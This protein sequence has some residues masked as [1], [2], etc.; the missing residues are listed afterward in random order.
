MYVTMRDLINS[1]K[2]NNKFLR[3]RREQKIGKFLLY[4][5]LCHQISLKFRSR[6]D[7]KVILIILNA[8]HKFM[9]KIF[10]IF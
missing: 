7:G 1:E 5:R 4:S 6:D 9:Y 3:H 10:I 8:N 2:L